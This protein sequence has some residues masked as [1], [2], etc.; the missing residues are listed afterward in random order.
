MTG[1]DGIRFIAAGLVLATFCMKQLVPLRALAIMSNVTFILYGYC[2]RL[3]PVLVLHPY[4]AASER[5]PASA[6]AGSRLPPHCRPPRR[7]D[8]SVR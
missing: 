5:L 2:A 4:S 7:G 1:L 3:Y 6:S 8:G